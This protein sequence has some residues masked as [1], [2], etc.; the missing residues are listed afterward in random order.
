M[1]FTENTFKMFYGQNFYY[2]I[3]KLIFFYKIPILN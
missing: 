3:Y 2:L 1:C